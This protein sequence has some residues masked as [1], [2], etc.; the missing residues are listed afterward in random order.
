MIKTFS[1]VYANELRGLLQGKI[2]SK[3]FKG[4][5]YDNNQKFTEIYSNH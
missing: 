4:V 5:V 3:N 1:V 2:A